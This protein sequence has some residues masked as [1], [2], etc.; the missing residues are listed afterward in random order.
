MRIVHL[1][2]S[3]NF[4]MDN[5]GF[6]KNESILLIARKQYRI[7]CLAKYAWVDYSKMITCH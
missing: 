3:T 6:K 7:F 1:N 2:M 5:R 4:Q